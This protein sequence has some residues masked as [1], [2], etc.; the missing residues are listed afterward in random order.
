VAAV[1]RGPSEVAVTSLAIAGVDIAKPCEPGS[2]KKD[3]VY[4]CIVDAHVPKN[5]ELTTPYFT[6]DYWKKPANAA[7]DI[8]APDVAFGVPF[9]PTPFHV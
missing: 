8:Y 5:A 9:R 2:A 6:D 1:N 7:I 4:I 3:A